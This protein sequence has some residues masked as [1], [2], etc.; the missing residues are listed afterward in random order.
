MATT[1]SSSTLPAFAR[2]RDLAPWRRL[3]A[4]IAKSRSRRHFLRS[5]EGLE[6]HLIRDIGLDPEH[7]RRMVAQDRLRAWWRLE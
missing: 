2:L 7:V 1:G 4:R 5:V 6:P 3:C